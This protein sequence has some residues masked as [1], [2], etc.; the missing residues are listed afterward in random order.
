MDIN[1]LQRK[2]FSKK[3]INFLLEI[4]GD[5]RSNYLKIIYIFHHSSFTIYINSLSF[6]LTKYVILHAVSFSI[7]LMASKF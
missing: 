2:K 4:L 1:K 7:Y 5:I 6:S 3:Y